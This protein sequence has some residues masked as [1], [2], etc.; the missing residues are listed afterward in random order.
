MVKET[1]TELQEALVDG[2]AGRDS[3]GEAAKKKN[4]CK[5][6]AAGAQLRPSTNRAL[7]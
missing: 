5:D 2:R 7:F 1:F 4:T 3:I 6:E